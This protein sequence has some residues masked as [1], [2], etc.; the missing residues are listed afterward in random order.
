MAAVIVKKEE[1]VQKILNVLGSEVSEEKFI[2][3]FKELYP[4]DWNNVKAK[5]AE[6]EKN[7]AWED[8]PYASSKCLHKEYV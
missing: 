6:E 1:K 3:K 7:E 4:K 8:S 5:Y 2:E